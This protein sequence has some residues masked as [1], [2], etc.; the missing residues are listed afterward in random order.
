MEASGLCQ[1]VSLLNGD[2]TRDHEAHKPFFSFLPLELTSRLFFAGA[3]HDYCF[4]VDK[5]DHLLSQEVAG[6]AT[7]SARL[8]SAHLYGGG[9]PSRY[10]LGSCRLSYTTT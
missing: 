2:A 6:C 3:A 4:R 9:L 10:I 7:G 5:T 8:S 1:L